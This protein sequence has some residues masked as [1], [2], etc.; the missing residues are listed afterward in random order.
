MNGKDEAR[1]V[2]CPP[3]VCKC[4]DSNHNY[5]LK[6]PSFW[7]QH[8]GLNGSMRLFEKGGVVDAGVQND[9]GIQ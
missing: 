9:G 4:R 7:C 1:E 8:G 5:T 6:G 3:E 2:N